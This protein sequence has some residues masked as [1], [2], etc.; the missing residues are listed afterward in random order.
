MHESSL[1]FVLPSRLTS[2]RLGTNEIA[3]MRHGPKWLGV[4]NQIG[5]VEDGDWDLGGWDGLVSG[6]NSPMGAM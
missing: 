4:R 1:D 2:H 3:Q 5:V 6:T